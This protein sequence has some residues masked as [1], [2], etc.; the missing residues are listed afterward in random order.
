[1]KKVI[2]TTLVILSMAIGFAQISFK[3]QKVDSIPKT[4]AQIYSDTKMFIAEY[5]KSAQNIIQNDDKKAGV[6]L[7][8]GESIVSKYFQLNDHKW[9]YSYTVKFFF[10]EKKYKIVIENVR[11]V[12]AFCGTNPWPLVE[13]CDTCKFPGIMKTSLNKERY[14]AVLLSLKSELQSIVDNYDK[15]IKTPNYSNGDW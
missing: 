1:M 14:T 10:K 11:C 4:K 2:L 3:W 9:T 15:I 12:S 8:K 7:I 5:W 13:A 6:I